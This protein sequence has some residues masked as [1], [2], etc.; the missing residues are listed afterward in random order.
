MTRQCTQLSGGRRLFKKQGK[1]N[2]ESKDPEIGVY[3]VDP[4][5][6]KESG[7]ESEGA[8]R[9]YEEQTRCLVPL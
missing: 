6:K 7:K 1:K 9:V 3:L 8:V 4:R 2:P 5:N